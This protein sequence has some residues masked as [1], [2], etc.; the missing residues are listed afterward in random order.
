MQTETKPASLLLPVRDFTQ[1]P[2]TRLSAL[3]PS[4]DAPRPI[5]YKRA[6]RLAS[7]SRMP[8]SSDSN[9]EAIRPRRCSRKHHRLD[10]HK[11]MERH[12]A[13]HARRLRRSS[14]V[15]PVPPPHYTPPSG[16][17]QARP[18]PS[19]YP[20]PPGQ[21]LT[22]EYPRSPTL[23]APHRSARSRRGSSGPRKLRRQSLAQSA[24][25]DHRH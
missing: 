2:A 1:I 12:P 4:S 10:W 14:T 22:M 5:R 25:R 6:F 19:T 18:L 16:D 17:S 11:N 24:G 9:N 7:A 23:A 21:E 3:F 13:S 20:S 15:P 8:G